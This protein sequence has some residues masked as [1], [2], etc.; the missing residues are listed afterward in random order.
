MRKQ[1]ASAAVLGGLGLVL[2]LGTAQAETPKQAA[3]CPTQAAG[4]PKQA[5]EAPKQA[6]E[7]PMQA[8]EGPTQAGE[9]AGP[10]SMMNAQPGMPQYGQAHVADLTGQLEDAFARQF[11]Q[12]AIDQAKL[13]HMIAQV[14]Q[15]FPEAARAKVK[16]HIDEVF[17]TGQRVAS[18]MP[19]EDRSKAVAPVPKEKLGTVQQHQLAGWGWGT[20]RGFGGFG[21][22]GF[23]GMFWGSGWGSPWLG[24]YPAVG[25]YGTGWGC[26]LGGAWCGTGL[27]LGSWYW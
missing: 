13:A 9:G 22:F 7:G 12:N 15:A 1:I 24:A 27:G 26:G 21:A 2:T 8:A 19:S 17:E 6:P 5:A 4:A 14:I 18:Q 10:E 20:A 16:I 3:E 11:E 25:Y 23:P